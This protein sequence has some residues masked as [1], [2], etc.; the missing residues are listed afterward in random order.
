MST[1]APET[2][3]EGVTHAGIALVAADTGRVFLCKRAFDETDAPEVAETWEFPGGGLRPE[4]DPYTAAVREVIEETGLALPDDSE[5]INGW[6]SEDGV[7]QCFVVSTGAEFPV[8]GWTPTTEVSDIGWFDY[9]AVQALQEAGALR[10]EVAA[11]TDWTL[12]FPETAPQEGTDMTQAAAEPDYAEVFAMPIPIHGVMAPEGVATGDKRGFL[13]GAM[14]K[15][16]YRLPFRWQETDTGEH[17]GA[18]VTGSVDRLMRKDGLIHYEGQLMPSAKTDQF[19]D[20]MEFFGGRYGVSVDG[21]NGSL[22]MVKSKADGI[23]WFDAVRASGLTAVDIP[24]FSEA[25]VAFGPHPDMPADDSEEF[26][27]MVAS[28][29]IV[30]RQAFKRGPGWV[31]NPE[32]T[33]RIHDYWTK[34]GEPG[35]IKIG[36]GTPGDFRRAKA[37]IGEKILKNSPEKARFLNQ[38][39]AQW[40]FDAL[41]YWP[42]DLGKPGNAPDTPENRKRAAT[43]ASLL[44]A[45]HGI[46]AAEEKDNAAWEAVLVSSGANRVRPPLEYF[47]EHPDSMGT[48]IEKPDKNGFQRTYGMA[49]EWGVC[50]IGH[51]NRCVEPPRTYSDDYPQFHKGVTRLASGKILTGVLTYNVEHRDAQKILTES[52]TQS[53]FDNLKNAWAAVRIGENDRGI[54]FSGVVLPKVDPDDLV[55]IE[56]SGQVSGEW[57]YG[58]LRALLTVNVEGFE[59]QRPSAEYDEMGNVVALAASAFGGV[60]DAPCAPTPAERMAALRLIEA[61]ERAAARMAALRQ[62]WSA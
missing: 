45:E 4:E 8:E 31:T 60:P 3:Y 43:H 27:V 35:Y 21:D 2:G 40:H 23:A 50:H 59:I 1:A 49:A 52:A 41:G 46:V 55:K 17:N 26:A 37:L 9:D 18:R 36:W 62:R 20:L 48:V 19:V 54:W 15:R 44:P 33:R 14:S 11:Q 10:P 6:R 30:G 28:G 53:H 25:Y 47:H 61:E 39:I 51:G 57:K 32:D 29:D 13:D 12:V 56:A 22:D 34:K 58:A 38:I 5:V 42:G 16:S 24:A 7:Y